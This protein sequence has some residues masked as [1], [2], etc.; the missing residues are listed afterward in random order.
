MNVSN[1]KRCI[2]GQI[3]RIAKKN[4]EDR[5]I[6]TKVYGGKREWIDLHN[7]LAPEDHIKI[8][9][10]EAFERSSNFGDVQKEAAALAY[11]KTC[12]RLS[13]V[14]RDDKLCCYSLTELKSFCESLPSCTHVD[15]A[16][17]SRKH[18]NQC[19]CPCSEENRKWR[20]ANG[21]TLQQI[22]DKCTTNRFNMRGML[23]H[24]K[25][26]SKSHYHF[27]TLVYLHHIYKQYNINIE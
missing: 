17:Y 14:M 20:E 6:A 19:I 3:P 27:A 15:S 4:K 18:P 11:D 26:N 10:E 5:R 12:N 22:E 25:R 13:I 7:S 21:I 8:L 2:D 24:C 1:G 9:E 16:Y 23:D